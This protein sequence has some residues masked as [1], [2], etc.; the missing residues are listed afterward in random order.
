MAEKFLIYTTSFCS[1]CQAAKRLLEQKGLNYREIDLTQD[2]ELRQKIS[3][4]NGGYRT[5]PMIFMEGK[6]VG[7]FTELKD[8]FDQGKA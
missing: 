6:F 8:L 4:E 5:V 2:Q 1:Y 7:G 3:K